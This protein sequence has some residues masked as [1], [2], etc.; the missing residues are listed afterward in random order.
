MDAML[1]VLTLLLVCQLAG[2]ILA[3]LSGLPLPGPVVGMVLLFLWLLRQGKVDSETERVAGGLL[4]H[5]SLLFVPAG[6]GVVLHL[7]LIAAEWVAILAALFVSTFVAILV[8]AYTMRRLAK[9]ED[10]P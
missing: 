1:R 2:E 6:V 5:L 9:P 3:R 4:E 10:A 7:E 8:A